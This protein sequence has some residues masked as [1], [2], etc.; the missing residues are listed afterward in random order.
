MSGSATG[1]PIC[2]EEHQGFR[3][4]PGA[5]TQ[6]RLQETQ[7]T[8]NHDDATQRWRREAMKAK[9]EANKWPTSGGSLADIGRPQSPTGARDFHVEPMTQMDD[10][11]VFR[12]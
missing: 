4:P 3:D 8:A 1:K 7:V 10:S 12:Y 5:V 2:R 11:G 9:T 6:M